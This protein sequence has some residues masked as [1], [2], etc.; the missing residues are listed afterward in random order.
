MNKLNFG[1]GKDL[2]KGYDNVDVKDFD[3]NVFPYPI[4]D[5]RY[6]EVYIRNVL[7][8]LQDPH[9]VLNEVWRICKPNAIVYIRCPHYANKGAYNSLQ[10]QHYFSERAFTYYA[11]G[12]KAMSSNGKYILIKLKLIPTKFGRFFPKYIREKVG[13]FLIESIEV[14]LEV[15]K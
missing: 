5:N 6:E 9:K 7:E 15:I 8:Y 4:P 10:H 13:Y 1:C 3:F 12:H 14:E 2:K 11:N